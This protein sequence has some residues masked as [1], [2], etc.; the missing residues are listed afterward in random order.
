MN[1]RQALYVMALHGS[2]ALACV[3][4]ATVL[5]FHGSLDGQTVAVIFG[6]AVGLAGGS[7]SSL[8]AL[9]SVVNGKSVV[10]AQM[11]AEQGAT[12]R[13]AIVSAA[14]SP[15]HKVTASEPAPTE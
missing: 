3:V 4:A 1:G 5:G 6:T 2:I 13:T 8:G 14:A 10:S 7:A 12:A 15:A 11:L 9:G